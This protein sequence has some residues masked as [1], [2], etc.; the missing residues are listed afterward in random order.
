[1][2][3]K[4]RSIIINLEE[5]NNLS[6]RF[7]GQVSYEDMVKAFFTVLEAQAQSLKGSYLLT[8]P[9]ADTTPLLDHIYD[10]INGCAAVCLH[11]INPAAASQ[12]TLTEQA[13]LN[14][15]NRILE[16]EY[17]KAKAAKHQNKPYTPTVKM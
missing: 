13:V 6:I 3:N 12:K 17:R 14:E 5:N 7:Q 4:I 1:M 16:R 11:N 8:N 10:E 15:E 2:D 9:N